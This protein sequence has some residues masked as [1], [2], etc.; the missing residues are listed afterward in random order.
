MN[1]LLHQFLAVKIADRIQQLSR[2]RCPGCIG[3]YILDNF[4][5]CVNTPLEDKI[6]I[7]I[8]KVKEEA[9]HKIDTLIDLYLLTWSEP[10][11]VR[12]SAM[13]FIVSL[14]PYDLLD[15]RYINEDTVVL[16]PF[17]MSWLLTTTTAAPPTRAYNKTKKIEKAK[18]RN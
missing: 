4:H 7:F 13:D 8:P 10:E 2:D 17:N 12:Q 11:V 1:Y 6:N 18:V 5:P 14:T 9:L 3:N 15:R 16:H